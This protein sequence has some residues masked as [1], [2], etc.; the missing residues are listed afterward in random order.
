MQ[1][2]LI[3]P[4]LILCLFVVM[5]MVSCHGL[6]PP[7]VNA[8]DKVKYSKCL[9]IQK[10]L[11][12]LW[13]ETALRYRMHGLRYNIQDGTRVYSKEVNLWKR[14]LRKKNQQRFL[15]KEAIRHCLRIYNNEYYSCTINR[16]HISPTQWAYLCKPLAQNQ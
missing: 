14:Q 10:R 1:A 12:D 16:K 13:V 7:G 2:V 15:N 3:F 6:K 5:A 11:V 8:V 9:E 4:R